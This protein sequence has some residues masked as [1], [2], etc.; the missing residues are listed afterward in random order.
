MNYLL[1]SQLPINKWTENNYQQ[2]ADRYNKIQSENCQHWEFIDG[3][4]AKTMLTQIGEAIRDYEGSFISSHTV[5][6]D[7]HSVESQVIS[8]EYDCSFTLDLCNF[9]RDLLC[10]LNGSSN[11]EINRRIIFAILNH[12]F[13][14]NQVEIAEK[15]EQDKKRQYI[16]SRELNKLY[17]E[18]AKM[19]FK[20]C[21]IQ[22][23]SEQLDSLIKLLK[24][25]AVDGIELDLPIF[26]RVFVD[27]FEE[28]FEQI[29]TA[30][31]VTSNTT[32]EMQTNMM[33]SKIEHQYNITLDEVAK[34][35]LSQWIEKNKKLSHR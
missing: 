4:Q 18:I 6:I 11:P 16:V 29:F 33:T 26:R 2:V 7:D 14:I 20:H 28:I 17:Q 35:Y 31:I 8:S 24:N 12:G 13:N 27:D 3:A 10:T 30:Y 1:P 34:N 15:C 9:I 21:H 19:Y 32:I 23:S 22:P 25:K 5:D